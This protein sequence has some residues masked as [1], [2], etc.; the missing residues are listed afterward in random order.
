MKKVLV[1]FIIILAGYL[2][3]NGL[4]WIGNSKQQNEA[5]IHHS[6]NEILV[7]VSGISTKI[8]P[9]NRSNLSAKLEGKG[10][11]AVKDSGDQ[12]SVSYKRKWLDWDWIPF[13][14]HPKLTIYLPKDYHRNLDLKIGAGNLELT[15][16]SE[17]KLNNLTVDM[18]AG[19]IKLSNLD[20][21]RFKHTGAAGNAEIDNLAVEDGS[22][23]ISSGNVHVKHYIGKMN[24]D[25]T[26]G[27]FRVQLDKVTDSID[28]DVSSGNVQLDLPRKADYT[29]KGTIVS[30]IVSNELSLKNY[31]KDLRSIEGTSGNGKHAITLHV[32][33]GRIK[34]Y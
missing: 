22:F 14:N 20:V 31:H 17:M 12:I 2:V 15:P 11:V 9:E 26:S 10:T 18:G 16:G 29:L 21:D 6:T 7:D 27:N 25:L 23:D 3:F 34:L 5:K 13:T 19:N 4:S 1:L 33:S 30:G 24:A 32:T 28:V 8:I